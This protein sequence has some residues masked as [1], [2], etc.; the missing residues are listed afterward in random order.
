MRQSKKK[1][2]IQV[3]SEYLVTWIKQMK[4]ASRHK[5]KG[6]CAI[7]FQRCIPQTV[8]KD[9][10]K[11]TSGRAKNLFEEAF[12]GIKLDPKRARQGGNSS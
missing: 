4:K 1:E 10:S 6:E 8:F 2:K 7:C 12:Y 11:L 3:D 5:H 9:A